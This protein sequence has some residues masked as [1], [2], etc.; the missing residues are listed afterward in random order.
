MTKTKEFSLNELLN[1][2]KEYKEH[3][4]A[5]EELCKKHGI[6]LWSLEFVERMNKKIVEKM[7]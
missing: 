5:M 6:S 3:S 1:D 4:K 7:E 2:L